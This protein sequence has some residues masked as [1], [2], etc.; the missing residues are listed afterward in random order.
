MGREEK[1][2]ERADSQYGNYKYCFVKCLFQL[3]MSISVHWNAM[4]N[5]FL[6]VN[7]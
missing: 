3:Y 2:R 5:V 1:G 4:S 6:T 7:S